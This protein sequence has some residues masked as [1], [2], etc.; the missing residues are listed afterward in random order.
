MSFQKSYVNLDLI[1]LTSCTY[2]ATGRTAGISNEGI[3][4][5]I[6]MSRRRLS[7]E[8][9]DV[10]LLSN[11]PHPLTHIIIGKRIINSAAVQYPFHGAAPDHTLA[12][13]IV[14]C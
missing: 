12:D 11:D 3:T 4:G 8:H 2:E 5:V 10:I 9:R 6:T 1:F 7:S 14:Q 13:A